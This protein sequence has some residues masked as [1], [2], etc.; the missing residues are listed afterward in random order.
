M[1]DA[2]CESDRQTEIDL[3]GFYIYIGG[4]GFKN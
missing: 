4:R 2:F 1:D 3:F